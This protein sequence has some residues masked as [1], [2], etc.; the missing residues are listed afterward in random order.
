MNMNSNLY[1]L[2]KFI[3]IYI[4]FVNM[5]LAQEEVSNDNLPVINK[6]FPIAVVDM[7]SIVGQSFAAVKVREFIEHTKKEFTIELK[8][9]EEALK[10]MQEELSS[11]RSILPPD[12]F[13]ELE[14]NFRKRVEALQKM[15]AEKNQLLED[16]LSRSVQKIQNEAIKIITDIGTEKGIALT[17]DTSTVVIAANSINISKSVIDLLNISLP[18]LDMVAIMS[19]GVNK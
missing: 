13:A 16:V 5:V 6:T 1:K 11:Q 2:L 9:E 18:E 7:Q 12:K 15:V 4:F 3:C 10:L 8:K 19:I 17:L 14:G